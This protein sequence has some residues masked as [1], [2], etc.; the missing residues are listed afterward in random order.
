MENVNLTPKDIVNKNFKPKMR[1]YD[2]T[3]VD[4]FLDAV[5]QDYEV[6]TSEIQKLQADNEKLRSRVDELTKQ[7]ERWR[8]FANC[9]SSDEHDQHGCVET[10]F[11]F[12]TSCVWCTAQ[13]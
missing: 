2:P 7:V 12:G 13:R 8:E 9:T 6:F 5:I 10:S 4:E 3:E 11:Q 1:G